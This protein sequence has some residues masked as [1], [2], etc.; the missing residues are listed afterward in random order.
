MGVDRAAAYFSSYWGRGAPGSDVAIPRSRK[1][2]QC[3]TGTGTYP[4]RD[5]DRERSR[6]QLRQDAGQFQ[7]HLSG[8]PGYRDFRKHDSSLSGPGLYMAGVEN[9]RTPGSEAGIFG[10]HF[11]SCAVVPATDPLRPYFRLARDVSGRLAL[12]TRRYARLKPNPTHLRG[13]CR[14]F[15][16]H[17]NHRPGELNA[18]AMG[19]QDAPGGLA[20]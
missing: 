14:L 2:Y 7:R 8:F 10:N 17:R 3:G 20:S 16:K 9:A 1:F 12:C 19:P 15:V 13:P 6:H 5:L 11:T 18:P 4:R